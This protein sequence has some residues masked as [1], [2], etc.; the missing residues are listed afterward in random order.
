MYPPRDPP[1][2]RVRQPMVTHDVSSPR[3]LQYP[4]EFTGRYDGAPN[5]CPRTPPGHGGRFPLFTRTT[6]TQHTD[7][8]HIT[9]G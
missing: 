2:D 6:S 9:R 3:S 7:A 4:A 5:L 8:R 1:R